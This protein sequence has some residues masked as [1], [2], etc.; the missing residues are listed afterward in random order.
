MIACL[1][2]ILPLALTTVALGATVSHAQS[3][4]TSARKIARAGTVLTSDDRGSALS[5]APGLLAKR[6]DTRLFISLGVV[7]QNA[8]IE[9]SESGVIVE[10]LA[11]ASWVGEL[12]LAF[13]HNTLHMGAGFYRH[14]MSS[15]VYPRLEPQPATVFTPS[16]HRFLRTDEFSSDTGVWAGVA[17]RPSE[18]LGVG[19]SLNAS[20]LANESFRHRLAQSL[21]SSSPFARRPFEFT[22]ELSLPSTR[23]G[24]ALG[25]Y[26]APYAFPIE[27]NYSLGFQGN[28]TSKGSAFVRTSESL[29]F[30]LSGHFFTLEDFPRSSL[31]N[32]FGVRFLG[33]RLSVEGNFTLRNFLSP[34]DSYLLPSPLTATTDEGSTTIEAIES[35]LS[36]ASRSFFKAGLSVDVLVPKT[37]LLVQTGF[38]HTRFLD[39][40][41]FS[42]SSINTL[43]VGIETLSEGVSFGFGIGYEWVPATS[44]LASV[45]AD[46]PFDQELSE[47]ASL[48]ISENRFRFSIDMDVAF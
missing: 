2:I 25:L 46:N 32:A 3:N 5:A 37:P 4:H 29:T 38:S 12:G 35:P 41:V 9:H 39:D 34:S 17:L 24:A 48:K 33:K 13:T 15:I 20:R 16:A 19:L 18:S 14:V 23:V 26:Y 22:Q 42:R 30:D 43:G 47:E 1:R 45:L 44:Q 28:P 10:N 11:P 8:N 31:S 40:N 7:D 21:D 36:D 27:I 6:E